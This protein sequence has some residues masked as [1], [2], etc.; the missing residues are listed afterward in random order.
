MTHED[1]GELSGRFTA[2]QITGE[3]SKEQLIQ[4][5][6]FSKMLVDSNRE[7]V[8][9]IDGLVNLTIISNQHLENIAKHTRLLVSIE[10]LLVKIEDHSKNL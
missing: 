9:N 10:D 8:E 4:I 6:Q 2:L 3:E 1:A 5:S 7:C